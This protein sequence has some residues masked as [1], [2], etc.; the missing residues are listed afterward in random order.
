VRE[1]LVQWRRRSAWLWTMVRVVTAFAVR[2]AARRLAGRR[3]SGAMEEC[4]CA[5]APLIA[6][7]LLWLL[8]D[9]VQRSKA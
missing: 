8:T 6:F 9:S 4:R 3:E 7:A 1:R 2:R 5:V